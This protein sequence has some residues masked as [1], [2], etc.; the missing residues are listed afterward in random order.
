MGGNG[1]GKEEKKMR[2][3]STF[4]IHNT[5]V[6]RCVFFSVCVCVSAY[7][8]FAAADRKAAHVRGRMGSFRVFE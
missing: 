6:V 4:G 5:G 1:R 8:T 3:E 2:A 7:V